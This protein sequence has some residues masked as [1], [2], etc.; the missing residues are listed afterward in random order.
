[1]VIT[2][3]KI[4]DLLK[5]Y[6]KI[7]VEHPDI[8]E[9]FTMHPLDF[10]RE[11]K[12][13]LLKV[14]GLL[15][16][17]PKRSLHIELQSFF[18]SIGQGS[19]CC[20]KGAFSLQRSKLKPIFFKVW[21]Q[22]LI[23]TY[24]E[25]YGDNIKRWEGFKLLAVDGSNISVVN[26][27]E[28]IAHFGTADNQFGSV[29]M[30]R[31]LQ[32]HDVL[33]DITIWGD[34][35]PRSY[36]ESTILASNIERLPKDSLTLLD[37]GYPSYHLIYRFNNEET[38]RHFLMRC[39][40]TFSNEV[41]KFV[42]SKTRDKVITIYPSEDSIIRLQQQGH[43]VTKKQGIKVR[44][45][46]IVLPDG[47]I[48]ILLTNLYNC[49]TYTLKKL[50]VLYFM[51]WKIETAYSKQ[52]NQLQ[53]EI[54]SGHRVICIEQDYM[55][56][57]FVA[58]L[59]SIIEKQCEQQINEISSVRFYDYKVNKNASWAFLKNRILKLFILPMKSIDILTELQ[60]LFMSSIE[61][62]RPDRHFE[63]TNPKRKR[64]KYQT[65]TNYRRAV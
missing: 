15:I 19:L 55:A 56:G 44:A 57:L 26:V 42:A 37:R 35:F 46:K 3:V 52:K 45:L 53:I 17:L 32:I 24:Y 34:I 63:R 28:V 50:S 61:P 12:L 36:G 62:I 7:I 49:N 43:I 54:Y 14:I 29:P 8:R 21:N 59:Q 11:R 60:K 20:T 47:E 41:K 18:E 5:S 58:N 4:I 23:E 16:N 30:A 13:P 2:N 25:S 48:E 10:S 64:G 38:P 65:F 22:L 31:G 40:A 1:M 33:N 51:R 27:P 39:K 6:L 9:H